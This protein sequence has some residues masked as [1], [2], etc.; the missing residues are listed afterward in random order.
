M[1]ENRF[2]KSVDAATSNTLDNVSDNILYN[3]K[4]NTLD[5]ILPNIKHNI[6]ESLV[7][8]EKKGRGSNHTFYLSYEVGEALTKLSTKTKQ[9]KS[10][11][12]N[13]VLKAILIENKR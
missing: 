11:I 9:S 10:T 1:A 4:D 6:L 12:V 8:K 3:I 2:R 7:S 5:N 13:D